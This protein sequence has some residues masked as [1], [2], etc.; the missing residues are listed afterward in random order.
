MAMLF[1]GHEIKC[2][3]CGTAYL[4]PEPL[5]VSAKASEKISF[6]CPYGHEAHFPSKEQEGRFEALQRERDR[7]KQQLAE[8]DDTILAEKIARQEAERVAARAK[9]QVTRIKKR[10]S[11]GVCPCCNRHFP[12]LERHMATKHKEPA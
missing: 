8:K 3:K 6:F 4:L 2:W 1:G 12:N 5:Y 11:A 9:G 10:V 7:L